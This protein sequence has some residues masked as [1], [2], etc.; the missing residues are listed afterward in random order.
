MPRTCAEPSRWSEC[1]DPNTDPARSRTH[2]R[3]Y[4]AASHAWVCNETPICSEY[5]A[6]LWFK[7]LIQRRSRVRAQVVHHYHDPLRIGKMHIDQVFHTFSPIG[8]RPAIGHLD[9]APVLEWCEE[10]EQ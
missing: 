10:H 2:I 9:V 1:A 3:P 5:G 7:C 6:L 8:I 4:S